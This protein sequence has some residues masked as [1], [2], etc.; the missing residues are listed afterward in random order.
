MSKGK[1]FTCQHCGEKFYRDAKQAK[2]CSHNCQYVAI[3]ERTRIIKEFTCQYCG[4]IFQKHHR[5]SKPLMYCSRECW[6]L[7]RTGPN[8]PNFTSKLVNCD[9][10][11][12]EFYQQPYLIQDGKGNYCS[13]ACAARHTAQ[14]RNAQFKNGCDVPCANCGKIVYKIKS[15]IKKVNFCSP[16][17]LGEY[18]K[19]KRITIICAHCGK[20]KRVKASHYNKGA[21]YCTY[22][23]ARKGTLETS[24]E[25]LGYALLEIMGFEFHK[26][27]K[28]GCFIPDAYIPSLKLA[29]LFDGDYWHSKPDHIERD[30]RFNAYA[31]KIGIKV[32][33]IWGSE[34][35]E[36]YKILRHRIIQVAE[37]QPS[38]VPPIPASFV[39][40]LNQ[41]GNV[42][43]ALDLPS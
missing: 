39:P 8:N 4:E 15:H 18:R 41:N 35:K 37:L 40:P 26:Q 5:R 22:L 11:G 23:C 42:Q 3:S 10:C 1:E 31:K 14:E 9:Y 2:Y 12:K 6:R 21:K 16:Q 43:L 38:E 29:V 32:V 7:A 34:L 25:S 17:C 33:R 24:L 13:R 19:R 27:Y 36:S 30:K 20:K 28:V